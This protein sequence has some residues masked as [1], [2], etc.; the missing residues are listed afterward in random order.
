MLAP[1]SG[2]RVH[3]FLGAV[4]V[5]PALRAPPRPTQPPRPP[6]PLPTAVAPA[7]PLLLKQP[8]QQPLSQAP[9]EGLGLL[10]LSPCLQRGA[11]LLHNGQDGPSPCSCSKPTEF[12]AAD[13]PGDRGRPHRSLDLSFQACES[14]TV[15]LRKERDCKR[16]GVL[17]KCAHLPCPQEPRCAQEIGSWGRADGTEVA[18]LPGY[19]PGEDSD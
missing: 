13:L 11:P 6:Q 12:L 14:G 19:P 7:R 10:I 18:L 9:V 17:P 3:P 8:V 4:P 1:S 15:T 16:C 5:P 2:A